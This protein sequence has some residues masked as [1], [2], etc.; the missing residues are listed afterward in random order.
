MA[1]NHEFG[2]KNKKQAEEK[3]TKIKIKS[4]KLLLNFGKSN[5]IQKCKVFTN[6]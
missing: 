6:L 4:K 3:N 1:K 2:K 5:K